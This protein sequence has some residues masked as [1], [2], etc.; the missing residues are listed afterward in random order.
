MGR[1]KI[2]AARIL[3]EAAAVPLFVGDGYEVFTGWGGLT[4]EQIAE[5]E[6]AEADIVSG[7]VPHAEVQRTIAEMR[8]RQGE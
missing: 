3:E 2:N 5:C 1:G 6:Q 8:V 7:G 4:P